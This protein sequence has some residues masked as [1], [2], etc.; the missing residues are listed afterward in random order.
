M[1]YRLHSHT[2]CLRSQ[3]Q[4]IPSGS[5]RPPWSSDLTL[6][7]AAQDAFSH[8]YRRETEAW[9]L[10]INTAVAS[11]ERESTPGPV[12]VLEA[13]R[14]S[15]AKAGQWLPLLPLP[16]MVSHSITAAP[17]MFLW[18]LSDSRPLTAKGLASP[19]WSTRVGQLF[20]LSGQ[21]EESGT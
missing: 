16:F 8:L 3:V 1:G 10:R 7:V 19:V 14:E 2:L 20:L 17:W 21:I 12:F 4:L 11:P 5:H 18:S 9:S 15:F 6:N 13:S